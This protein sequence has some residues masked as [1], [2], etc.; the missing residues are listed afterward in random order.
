MDKTNQFDKH[1]PIGVFD[2]GLGGLTAVKEIIEQL[3]HEDIVFFG[4]TARVPYGNRSRETIIEYSR[5]DM[6]FLLSHN[7]KIVCIA[8][9]T[10]D[11]MAR[12]TLEKEFDIPIIGAVGPAAKQ[13]VRLTK[14]KKIGVIG[15]AATVSSG[16]YRKV[17]TQLSPECT[18]YSQACPLLVP[19]IESGRFHKGDTVVETVLR[20][21]LL[22]LQAQGI[23]T[24]I[25]GC[26]HYPL[27]YAIVKD[28]LPGVEIVCS[29]SASTASLREKLA[30]RDLLNDS[31]TEGRRRFFVSD[32]PEE[33]AAN[34]SVFLG[35]S[36]REH[37][38]KADLD[39]FQ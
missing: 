6:R 27:L 30:S 3:P 37:C 15:T 28:I 10:V 13:A 23:D 22:P 20:D 2:S 38:E 36:V 39:T 33:F 7:V 35:M 12:M 32:A 14:N 16:A 25:L 8:C 21:Y 1:S 17:I 34:G 4:D 19:L 5:Q 29:G 9:N 24:I 18:V 31:K 26:T 11:S